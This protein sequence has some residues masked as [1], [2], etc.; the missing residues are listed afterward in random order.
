MA[1]KRLGEILMASGLI[2]SDELRRA[3]KEQQQWGGPL[4]QIMVEM[5]LIKELD[6]VFVLSRQLNIPV[7]DLEDREISREILDMVPASFCQENQ[8]IPFDRESIGNFLDVAMVEPLNMDTLD[9]LRVLTKSNIR[10]HFTTYSTLNRLLH[11]F[12]GISL[13]WEKESREGILYSAPSSL[14]L[15]GRELS[16]EDFQRSYSDILSGIRPSAKGVAK[17]TKSHRKIS[18]E[19]QTLTETD[20][21]IVDLKTRVLSCCEKTDELTSRIRELEALI[22]RDETILRRILGFLLDKGLCSRAELEKILSG[23]DS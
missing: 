18:G 16:T 11:R 14:Q 1:R 10:S 7:A 23:S 22:E 15:D 3:L 17:D 19:H 8:L 13:T 2:D 9:N 4:G 12:Y 6:L 21:R 5:G 20:R